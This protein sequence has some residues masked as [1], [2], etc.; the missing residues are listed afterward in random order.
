MK[1]AT[2][3]FFA[4]LIAIGMLLH[5]DYGMA[6]DDIAMRD[7]GGVNLNYIA[8]QYVPKDLERLDN[9]RQF[10]NKDY[11]PVFETLLVFLESVFNLQD[12][13]EV[14]E[15]RHLTVFIVFVIG[16]L[17]IFLTAKN[18]YGDYRWGLLAALML[19]LSPRIFA[20]AFYNTKD[21]VFMSVIAMSIYSLSLFLKNPSVRTALIHGFVTAL[22]IDIRIMGILMIIITL[23]TLTIYCVKQKHS[24]NKLIVLISMYIIATACLVILMWPFL[25]SDPWGNFLYALKNM[26]QFVRWNGHVLYWGTYIKA[27]NLPWHY[28]PIWIIVTTPLI[29][30]ALMLIGVVAI[31]K[32][33]FFSLFTDSLNVQNIIEY[34]AILC[35]TGPII[36]VIILDSVLY[37]GWRQLYFVYPAFILLAVKGTY[38]V[39]FFFKK[40]FYKK[41]FIGLIITCL[42]FNCYWIYLAHPHQNVYFNL[43]IGEDWKNKFEVDYWGLGNKQAILHILANDSSP[44]IT[45]KATSFTPLENTLKLLDKEDRKRVSVVNG[46]QIAN[47]IFDNYRQIDPIVPTNFQTSDYDLFFDKKIKNESIFRLYKRRHISNQA[48]SIDILKNLSLTFIRFEKNKNRKYVI[49]G[50]KNSSDTTILASSSIGTPVRISWRY[51]D[52]FGHPI[53]QWDEHR[54][55]FP[56]DLKANDTELISILLEDGSKAKV[57]NTLEV[58]WV[59]EGLFWGHEMGIKPLKIKFE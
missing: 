51:L 55:D 23:G 41:I 29:Y 35:L 48:Y 58:S 30:T 13:K 2:S 44:L 37:D 33:Q 9:L 4:I 11:G 18:I 34:V 16:V 10:Q 32:K 25:W 8:P 43:L 52:K 22:A 3:I 46:D 36:S 7:I 59:Q 12:S 38:T 5:K 27:D 28:V 39:Q 57:G 6:W 1:I 42:A 14:Y 45:I 26:S 47:Y 21:I 54:K 20:E 17:S 49:V 50:I 31:L 24:F 15:F 40:N 53:S 19:V 56:V